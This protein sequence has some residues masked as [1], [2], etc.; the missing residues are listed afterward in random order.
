VGI[1]FGF[2][3]VPIAPFMKGWILKFCLHWLNP[4]SQVERRNNIGKGVGK[5]SDGLV[6]MISSFTIQSIS[7]SFLY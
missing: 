3:W 5:F 6:G 4:M 7:L 2:S 1:S